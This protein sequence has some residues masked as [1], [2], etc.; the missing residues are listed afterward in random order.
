MKIDEAM[1]EHIAKLSRLIRM[2][3]ELLRPQEEQHV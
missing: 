3:L 1:V 2:A